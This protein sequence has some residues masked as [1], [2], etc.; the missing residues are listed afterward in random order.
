MSTFPIPFDRTE[1]PF[2]L[3]F[4]R[5]RL[6]E[7][8]SAAGSCFADRIFGELQKTGVIRGLRNP[9]GIAYNPYSIQ[10]SLRR[11]DTE[12][13]HTDFFEYDSL[14]HSWMHHGWFSASSREEA[15]AKAE[16]MRKEYRKNLKKSTFFLLTLSSAYVYVHQASGQIVANCHKVHPAEF[17]RELLS[18][19]SCRAAVVSAIRSIRALSPGCRIIVT[20]SPI[21]HDPGDLRK[22]SL[23]KGRLISAVHDAL[24]GV[25][26]ACYFPSYEILT[27]ELRD[28]RYYTEDLI[29]P[30]DT[31]YSIVLERFLK[32]CFEPEVIP[33][34]EEAKRRERAASHIERNV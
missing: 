8:G 29:H 3:P 6:K 5:I 18:H 12:Y 7:T 16:K 32:S 25:T 17:K 23:S 4:P 27:S 14:W 10:E 2:E 1:I 19:D 30:S 34:Y 28:Y 26:D 20:V 24:E 22:N 21:L 31:A 13:T 11:L 33:W 9:N 15:V